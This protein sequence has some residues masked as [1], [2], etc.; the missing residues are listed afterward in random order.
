VQLPLADLTS[1]NLRVRYGGVSMKLRFGGG[2]SA[3]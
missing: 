1:L 3:K 2:T